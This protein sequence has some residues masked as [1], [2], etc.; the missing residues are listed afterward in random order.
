MISKFFSS[1]TVS[2]FLLCSCSTFSSYDRFEG[3]VSGK[4]RIRV[5]VQ[6]DEYDIYDSAVRKKIADRLR[7]E[8]FQRFSAMVG[9]I[10]AKISDRDA[11]DDLRLLAQNKDLPA[12]IVFR[13]IEE[14]KV[15]GFIDFIIPERSAAAMKPLFETKKKDKEDDE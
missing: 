12:E 7:E 1:V 14:E 2:L 4:N 11:A 6:F 13:R 8:G 5:Y 9:Q 10:A 3:P 15:E